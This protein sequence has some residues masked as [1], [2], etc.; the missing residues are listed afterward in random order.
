M[1]INMDGKTAWP[2]TRKTPLVD[3]MINEAVLIVDEGIGSA[4]DVGNG[5]KYDCNRPM[6]PLELC[7]MASLDGSICGYGMALLRAASSV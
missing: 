6:G 2:T 3:P 7:D 4:A 1:V 5:M